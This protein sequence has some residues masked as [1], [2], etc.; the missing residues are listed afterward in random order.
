VARFYS[1]SVKRTRSILGPG[2]QST[3]AT[4]RTWFSVTIDRSRFGEEREV[5]V[6]PRIFMTI[7]NGSIASSS[8][9]GCRRACVLSRRSVSSP[10]ARR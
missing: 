1:R 10:P 3:T 9:S 6:L 4:S 2:P 7:C 5:I 8:A